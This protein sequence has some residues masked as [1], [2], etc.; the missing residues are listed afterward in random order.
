[1]PLLTVLT[2]G[3]RF[4]WATQENNCQF[5]L[6]YFQGKAQLLELNPFENVKAYPC[7]SL[8]FNDSSML[9]L[10]M[11]KA[12]RVCWSTLLA[13]WLSANSTSWNPLHNTDTKRCSL[14]ALK[15]LT[16]S[17]TLHR[18]VST[19]ESRNTKSHT[20]ETLISIK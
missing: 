4:D 9:L 5:Y 2:E 8:N 12:I 11:L 6:D 18:L 3:K 15:S 10:Q 19:Y 7:L 20:C 17:P 1:M 13:S 16:C 14:E